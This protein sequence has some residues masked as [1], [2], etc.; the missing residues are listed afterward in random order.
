MQPSSRSR[1]FLRTIA[2]FKFVK[3]VLL[4]V[5]GAGVLHLVNRDILSLAERLVE[6]FHLDPGK[7][8]VAHALAHVS[9]VTPKQ[10]HEIGIVAFIYGGLFLLEGIGLWS[11]KRW[12]EWITVVITGSLL[13]LETYESIHHPTVLR[14]AVLL[15]NAAI[16]IYLVRRIRQ[17]DAH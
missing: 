10:L 13:P 17:A 5:A 2:A 4:V 14:V 3:A 9:N 8:Y 16:V 12:G 1:I 15:M 6:N 11:L 7:P